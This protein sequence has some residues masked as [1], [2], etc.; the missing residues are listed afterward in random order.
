MRHFD[1]L[2]I[3][4][5]ILERYP[6]GASLEEIQLGLTPP[7]P[8]RTL[9]RKLAGLVEEE[10]LLAVGQTRS[11]RY[12]L[13]K[14]PREP[15]EPLPSFV[16][17]ES[18]RI[19]VQITKPLEKRKPVGFRREFLDNYQPN[20]SFYLTEAER[21]K[22]KELGRANGEL[23]AGTYAKNILHKLLLD[24]SWNSS[25]LEGNTYS[26]LETE[27]LLEKGIAAKGKDLKETQM[28]LNHKAAIEFLVGSA[29]EIG[30]NR[31]TILNLH[32]LLSDN[33]LPDPEASG[34]LRAIPVGISRSVYQPCAIPQLLQECFSLL[35]QKGAAIKDPFEQ[36]FFLMVYLPYLQAFDDVNKRTSRLASNIPLIRQ[37]LCPF[38][39][40]DVPEELYIHGL[41][42]IYEL[43][44]VEVLRD[45]FLWAY[46]RSCAMYAATRKVLGEP[47]PFRM[48]YRR[49]LQETVRK[50]ILDRQDK[51]S[52]IEEIRKRSLSIPLQDRERFIEIAEK[53]LLS[54]HE[55]N[56]ARYQIRL[57]EFRSWKSIW[58]KLT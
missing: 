49:A 52:A 8:R 28:I 22:L 43:N 42:A 41:L 54:L 55:G 3:L 17:T 40:I 56:I 12:K 23:P 16:S 47:D 36:A 30:I 44:R 10:I 25:R 58:E 45:L 37:N 29:E 19:L 33:L 51:Q 53:E 34:R 39:F 57:H 27:S 50:I 31:Y 21:M 4:L 35:L 11:R 48:T 1:L 15:Q 2:P 13:L 14:T 24:L 20:R 6:D 26:L 9:Q 46:E 38:S 32:T 5:D 18:A 7:I